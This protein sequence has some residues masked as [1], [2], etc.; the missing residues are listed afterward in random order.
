MRQGSVR[1]CQLLRQLLNLCDGL[2]VNRREGGRIRAVRKVDVR[3][4][5]DGLVDVVEYED[6]ITEHEDRLRNFKGSP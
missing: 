6:G 4:D 5:L 2:I 1:S 3:D